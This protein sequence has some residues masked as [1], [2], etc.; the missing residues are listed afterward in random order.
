MITGLFENRDDIFDNF[1]V[2]DELRKGIR[3]IYADY[4][5]EDYSGS[6]YVLFKKDGKYYDV[7][8]SHCSCMGLENQWEP[9]ETC[10]KTLLMRVEKGSYSNDKDEDKKIKNAILEALVDEIAERELLMS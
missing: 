2:S 6:A 4:S 3:I 8:G 1:N 9:T 10:E 5:D 7:A